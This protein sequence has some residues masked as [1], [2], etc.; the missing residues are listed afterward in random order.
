MLRKFASIDIGQ[1][2]LPSLA[3]VAEDVQRTN[4]PRVLRR[5]DEDVAIIAPIGKLVKQSHGKRL[6]PGPAEPAST[7]TL[8]QVF[9]SVETP[10]HLQGKDDID[11]MIQEAKEERIERLRA[12]VL[13]QAYPRFDFE[14]ARAVAMMER[15][16]VTEIVSY[17]TDF[18][19]LPGIIRLEPES[20][21]NDTEL[22]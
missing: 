4:Q 20:M 17:D 18:D 12:L 16:G 9:G 8:E 10:L 21:M 15:Q 13:Y 14:D 3:D 1:T 5:A 2:G 19:G 6:L 22:I 7:L 11:A